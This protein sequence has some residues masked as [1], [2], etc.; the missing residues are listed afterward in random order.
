L[1]C[2]LCAMTI[3]NLSRAR[4]AKQ[5]AAALCVALFMSAG[6]RVWADKAAA[7]PND[8]TVRPLML[9]DLEQS[10]DKVVSMSTVEY[11]PGGSSAPHRHDA[12][13]FVYVLEG[14]VRMQV[15]GSPAV[16]LG[17]GDTFY[18]GPN[19]VHT[20]SANASS[21]HI[22]RFLVVMIKNK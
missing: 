19:D 10:N 11:A 9:R 6:A 13:V 2:I 4:F 21:T 14:S 3:F 8:A 15:E 18:E 1:N 17:P 7:R 12:Q 16:T 5:A 22:A 20:V